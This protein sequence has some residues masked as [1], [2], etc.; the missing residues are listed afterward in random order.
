[1]EE[2]R[3]EEDCVEEACAEA[4]ATAGDFWGD[5]LRRLVISGLRSC[6]DAA[7]VRFVP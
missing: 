5:V 6:A 4:A 7:L 1:M 3:G 2:E